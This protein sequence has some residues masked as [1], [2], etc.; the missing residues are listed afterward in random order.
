MKKVMSLV[1]VMAAVP[2]LAFARPSYPRNIESF[3][4]IRTGGGE[5]EI[6]VIKGTGDKV[7]GQTVSCD[8]RNLTADEQAHTRFMLKGADAAD[9][10]A[11]FDESAI[12]AEEKIL[13]PLPET[14]SWMQISLSYSYNDFGGKPVNA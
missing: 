8:F 1:L 7:F 4:V 5:G 11:I 9:A 10:L 3:S 14:G 6:K 12:L 2:S 13:E